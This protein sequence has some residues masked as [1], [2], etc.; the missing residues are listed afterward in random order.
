MLY[1]LKVGIIGGLPS[2]DASAEDRM[3]PISKEKNDWGTA[4][5]CAELASGPRRAILEPFWTLLCSP[6]FMSR[7][8]KMGEYLRYRSVF[9]VE[10]NE[11]VILIVACQRSQQYEW[12]A[13]C[14]SALKA[15]WNRKLCRQSPKAVV[16]WVGPVKSKSFMTSV[17]N[18]SAPRECVTSPIS[19]QS[20]S[21]VSRV[22]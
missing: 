2:Y 5:C 1:I 16:L 11:F 10:L 7:L 20:I 18:Y 15:V 3:P 21:S 13:H 22:S 9:G 19:A 12:H 8:Q 14:P 6:E 17:K 4:D